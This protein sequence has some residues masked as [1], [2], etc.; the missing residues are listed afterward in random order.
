MLAVEM[1]QW[2]GADLR[3]HGDEALKKTYR[4]PGHRGHTGPVFPYGGVGV[5]YLK[6]AAQVG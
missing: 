6:T 5:G 1:C 4:G 2:P 3:Q